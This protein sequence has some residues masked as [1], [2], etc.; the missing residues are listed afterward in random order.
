MYFEDMEPTSSSSSWLIESSPLLRYHPNDEQEEKKSSS[1]SQEGESVVTTLL[2]SPLGEDVFTWMLSARVP[3]SNLIASALSS[4]L[5][6]L[7]VE[8]LDSRS[9]QDVLSSFVF[10]SLRF[11]A[12]C[13]TSNLGAEDLLSLFDA[14]ITVCLPPSSFKPSVCEWDDGT[15]RAMGDALLSFNSTNFPTARGSVRTKFDACARQVII[16][17]ND[18]GILR[19]YRS[20]MGRDKESNLSNLLQR[21]R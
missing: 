10:P 8:P 19:K 14:I 20:M 18:N 12:S 9:R 4:L 2:S 11:M 16:G 5:L 6:A 15:V 3:K 13:I 1:K 7:S 17:E 21:I